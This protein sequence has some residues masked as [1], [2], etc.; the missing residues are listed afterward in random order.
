MSVTPSA[1]AEFCRDNDG[2]LSIG[3]QQRSGIVVID[4]ERL[5]SEQPQQRSM[6]TV[7]GHERSIRRIG[8]C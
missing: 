8:V 5:A 3:N 4:C 7:S 1:R 2:G 6:I